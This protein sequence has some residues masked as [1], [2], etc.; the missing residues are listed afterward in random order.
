MI[1]RESERMTDSTNNEAA[2]VRAAEIAWARAAG[3]ATLFALDP[4]GSGGIT[5]RAAPGP[6]RDR[7]FEL[8]CARLPASAPRRRLPPHATDDRLLGGLDLAETLRAGRRVLQRGLLDEADGGVLVIPM[9]ERMSAACAAHLGG[10]LDTGEV[11]LERDGISARRPARFGVIAFDEGAGDD[12]QLGAALRDRLAFQLDFND[13][14][15]RDATDETWPDPAEVDEARIRLPRIAASAEAIETLTAT[16]LALGIISLRAPLQ[17]L[18][19]ARAA[20][21]LGG[22]DAIERDDITLAAQL[23]L[24]PRAQVVPPG[25][26]EESTPEEPPA[27]QEQG[28]A[29]QDAS[30]AEQERPLD[31]V[32]LDAVR[33]AIPAGLL[34]DLLHG[35]P[36]RA[37]RAA[38]GRAGALQKA[39]LRGRPIGTRAGRPDGRARLSVIDTLRAAAPWQ[40]LRRRERGSSHRTGVQVRADDFRIT[41][42]QQRS[43]TTSIFVVDASGSAALHRMG[44]AKGAVELLLADCYVRRDRVALIAFRGSGAELLLAPTRSLVRAKRSLAALPGGGGTPLAAGIGAADELALSLRQRGDTPL[45]I[46]LTDGRANVTA[47]GNGGR[48]HAEEEALAA[49]RNV[50][51]AGHACILIDTSP[52]P[53]PQG[54]RLAQEMGARYLPLPHA[55]AALLSQAVQSAAR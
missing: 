17:A 38:G 27:E 10:A 52:R 9:A 5:V 24:A 36:S 37:R 44:E 40:T 39:R 32:V 47:D 19:V 31:D 3:A 41:V 46:L 13:I 23:V 25:G 2:A 12:E 26:E 49:A 34:A 42:Y 53:Q 33:A 4:Q 45:L 43:P 1:A 50:R 29:D 51:S 21:A 55:D 54:L 30:T 22:R 7:W 16:A 20:A 14:A 11:V 6:V 48:A 18:A 35:G 28:D 8:L 15:V